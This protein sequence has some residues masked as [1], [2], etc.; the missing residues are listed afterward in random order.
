MGNLSK[1]AAVVIAGL[2]MSVSS[3]CVEAQD[4]GARSA[5][6]EVATRTCAGADGAA[7]RALDGMTLEDFAPK[8]LAS[9]TPCELGT[10]ENQIGMGG[11]RE[12]SLLP[13]AIPVRAEGATYK[14]R[15]GQLRGR[16]ARGA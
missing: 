3:V 14:E 13:R 16:S 12:A 1:L 8:A 2:V 11:E 5:S 10:L 15:R 7:N 6:R 9:L 4:N